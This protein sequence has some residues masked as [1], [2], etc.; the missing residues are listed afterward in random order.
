MAEP[1]WLIVIVPAGIGG[2]LVEVVLIGRI[3]TYQL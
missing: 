2:D 1:Q 3:T